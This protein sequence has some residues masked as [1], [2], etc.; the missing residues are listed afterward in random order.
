[1]F[2]CENC[3]SLHNGSYGSG[4][5]CTSKCARSFSTKLN[6]NAINEKVSRTFSSKPSTRITKLCDHCN[7]TFEVA[8]NKRSQK[9]CSLTCSSQSKWKNSDYRERI[10]RQLSEIA[11]DRHAAGEDFGWRTRDKFSC[12]YPETIAMRILEEIGIFYIKELRVSRYF[13]DFACVDKKIAIE[14]DGQQHKQKERVKSDQ[15]KDTLLL[16]QGWTIHRIKW[17]DEN[18]RERIVEI[19]K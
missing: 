19:F 14:I 15:R 6:R 3:Q 12:S 16:K 7:A 13:I 10:S 9:T 17:P 11:Y 18:I 8:Y 5:F 2:N 4:R 1:M